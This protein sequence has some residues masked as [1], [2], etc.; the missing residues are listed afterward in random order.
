MLKE[1][2]RL[3]EQNEGE[4]DLKSASRQLNAQPSAV[5][6]MVE[7]LVRMGRLTEVTPTCGPCESCGVNQQ[8]SL[9]TT[10]LKRY[11]ANRRGRAAPG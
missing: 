2:L 4:L 7:T 3:I 11:V 1:L 5:A 9:P 6:G 8:C 10:Q